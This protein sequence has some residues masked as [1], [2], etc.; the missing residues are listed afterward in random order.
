MTIHKIIDEMKCI[1]ANITLNLYCGG[2]LEV[3]EIEEVECLKVTLTEDEITYCGNIGSSTSVPGP[4]ISVLGCFKVTLAEED[5][6]SSHHVTRIMN[7]YIISLILIKC[8]INRQ[9]NLLF[10]NGDVMCC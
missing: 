10:M 5:D 2:L 3:K 4:S 9:S 8:Y 6:I 7:R 1:V